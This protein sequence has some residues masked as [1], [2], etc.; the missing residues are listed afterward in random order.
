MGS[1]E[2]AGVGLSALLLLHTSGIQPA[3]IRRHRVGLPV[4]MRRGS[5]PSTLC[6][7]LPSGFSPEVRPLQAGLGYDL[8][9]QLR[10]RLAQPRLRVGEDCGGF[11][12]EPRLAL[13]LDATAAFAGLAN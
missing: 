4:V 10:V 9:R 2:R 8:C 5:L 7:S 11:R 13:A 3:P 6:P 12:F 1:G